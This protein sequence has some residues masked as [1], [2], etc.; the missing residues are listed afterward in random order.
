MTVLALAIAYHAATT[1]PLFF[2]DDR[3]R[4]TK[5]GGFHNAA[6]APENI[7]ALYHSAPGTLIAFPT[8]EPS[9]VAVLDID[10]IKHPESSAW[11][12]QHAER[13]QTITIETRSGGWHC[14]FRH[15]SGLTCTTALNGIKGVDIRA[16]GGYVIAWGAHGHKTLLDAPVAPWPSWL[17][18]PA[19]THPER[20]GTP[21]RLP[22]DASLARLV[23]WVA[24]AREGER[25][26]RLF[27][28]GCRMAEQV[29]HGTVTTGFAGELLRRAGTDAGLPEVEVKK[30]VASAL[31][32]GAA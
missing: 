27:W 7:A 12:W 25:N 10:A 4:P 9:G 5:K 31:G 14:Y 30:T 22:D 8:G 11:F 26:S 16:N 23:R 24:D 13:L 15:R 18:P 2:C 28:A 29:R 17:A 32:G 20:P 3:K 1:R 19:E 6:R 21:A